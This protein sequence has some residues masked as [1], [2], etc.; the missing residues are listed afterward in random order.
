MSDSGRP[1]RRQ[2][3]RLPRPWDFPGKNTGVGCHFLLQCMKVKSESEVAQSLLTL[4]DPIDCSLPGSFVHGIFQARV[5]A[6]GAIAFSNI[7]LGYEILPLCMGPTKLCINISQQ[8]WAF[9]LSPKK[10]FHTLLELFTALSFYENPVNTTKTLEKGQKLK[11]KGVTYK[12]FKYTP[13]YWNRCQ[14][15][16]EKLMFVANYTIVDWGPHDIWLSNCSDY[17][18]STICDYVTQV[19]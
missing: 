5:L 7:S 9:V 11:C 14:A 13:V 18:N 8:T 2:P 3:T 19:T 6:W 12:N 10:N 17:I 16:S 4:S 1:H 15:K